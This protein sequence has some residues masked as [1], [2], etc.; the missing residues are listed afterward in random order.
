M[1]RGLALDQAQVMTYDVHDVLVNS[2][3][4]EYLRAPPPGFSRITIEQVRRADE[5]V[6]RTLLEMTS[7]GIQAVEDQKP[8][9]K[10]LKPVLDSA[11]VRMLI[12][13]ARESNDKG[14]DRGAGRDRPDPKKRKTGREH[15]HGAE[16]AKGKGKGKGNSAPMPQELIGMWRTTTSGKPM[17]YGYNMKKGCEHRKVVPGDRCPRGYHLCMQPHCGKEHPAYGCSE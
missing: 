10:L 9:D 11:A 12:T 4:D 8:L 17:C 2:L 6:F 13:P 16:R 14:G 7:E 15:D 5:E 3:M 1:R